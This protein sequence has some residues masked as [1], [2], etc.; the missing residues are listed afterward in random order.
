MQ[1]YSDLVLSVTGVPLRGAAITVKTYPAGATATIYSDNALTPAANPLT[2]DVNGRYSF[3]AADGR[4]SLD[5]AAAGFATQTISDVLLEDP[6]D[7][8]V[9]LA[10]S[11]GAALVGF[12]GPGA[13]AISETVQAALRRLV[14]TA[15]Y[16]TTA[17]FNT[18]SLAL[19]GS[20]GMRRLVF[21]T[22]NTPT[23]T[24][25]L[26]S[27]DGS[28]QDTGQWGYNLSDTLYVPNVLTEPQV[29]FGI[30]ANFVNRVE[31][32][33]RFS[34]IG[35]SAASGYME[36]IFCNI[37]RTSN[38]IL[39]TN[40][41]GENVNIGNTN[42]G[43]YADYIAMTSTLC[44]IT[45]PVQIGLG[46]NSPTF[47][48]GITIKNDGYAAPSDANSTSNGDKLVFW[49]AATYKPAIGLDNGS[50]WFQNNGAA[51]VSYKWYG[52]TSATPVEQMRLSA[53]GDFYT[54]STASELATNATGGFVHIPSCNGL[55][56]G[57]PAT[58]LTG[59]VPM[60]WDR[61]NLKMSVYTGG[62]WKQSAAFA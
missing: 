38:K 48:M 24:F 13:G 5:I 16:S 26:K 30:E 40:L 21:P 17:Q 45:N 8:S 3:Y 54:R 47:R 29:W 33:W 35:N 32:Y 49:N 60:I 25:S 28:G 53:T 10:A 39:Q 7:G 57:T 58:V 42:D 19:T 50:M 55:P 6:A 12:I 43:S 22:V 56:S 46:G 62:A 61:A 14:H 36:P 52:G 37:D 11:S 34:P 31:M 44:A 51:A 4:Y 23:A 20:F 9:A 2:S 18:A 59:A 15:Q 27:Y 41:R 1:K